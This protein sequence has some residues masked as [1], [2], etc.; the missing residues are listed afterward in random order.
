[1]EV[2]NLCAAIDTL[3]GQDLGGGGGGRGI[4]AT[5]PSLIYLLHMS[6]L[7][8]LYHFLQPG[9]SIGESLRSGRLGVGGGDRRGRGER[10]ELISFNVVLYVGEHHNGQIPLILIFFFPLFF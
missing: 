6:L 8:L 7:T 10:E 1:M 9:W 2:A 3:I 5:Q 4:T